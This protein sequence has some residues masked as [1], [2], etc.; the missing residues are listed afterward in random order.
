MRP[1]PSLALREKLVLRMR[2]HTQVV[3]VPHTLPLGLFFAHPP[4]FSPQT[5]STDPSSICTFGR[6]DSF[7]VSGQTT[8]IVHPHARIQAGRSGSLS[9]ST[10]STQRP[11][12]RS[13]TCAQARSAYSEQD[14]RTGQRWSWILY[15]PGYSVEPKRGESLVIS[16]DASV[17]SDARPGLDLRTAIPAFSATA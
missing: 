15:C 6:T 2:E 14:R 16:F 7:G 3:P 9:Q 8:I 12:C 13:C 1:M 17:C 4:L 10:H 11:C 5:P